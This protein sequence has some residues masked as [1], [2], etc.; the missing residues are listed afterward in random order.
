MNDEDMNDD[1]WDESDPRWDWSYEYD[2]KRWDEGWGGYC[3]CTSGGVGGIVDATFSRKPPRLQDG[4]SERAAD[5]VVE[6]SKHHRQEGPAHRSRP[7][8][9]HCTARHA[10][11]GKGGGGGARAGARQGEQAG[12]GY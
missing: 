4:S 12:R 11:V 9:L 2:S 1:W 10:T 3:S 7:L 5:L 6:V 8:P